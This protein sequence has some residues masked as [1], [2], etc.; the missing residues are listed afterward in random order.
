MSFGSQTPGNGCP[1][2]IV[3][4]MSSTRATV[5]PGQEVH[6]DV[7]EGV[8]QDLVRLGVD[9]ERD[10]RHLVH[11]VLDVLLAVA[12]AAVGPGAA[13]AEELRGVVLD[14][15]HRPAIERLAADE[16]VVIGLEPEPQK[17]GVGHERRLRGDEG[18]GWLAGGS[19]A[20]ADD[21]TGAGGSGCGR[22]RRR[23]RRR[24]GLDRRGRRRL[25]R[26]SRGLL[27]ALGA[28]LLPPALVA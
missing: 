17:V 28:P 15:E 5:R 13:L 9:P 16:G 18:R 23:W 1:I 11:L 12:D 25:R 10:Q 22:R 7:V 26:R 19:G 21:A 20:D 14:A 27:R 4:F 6:V 2:R 3:A 24:I 8:L